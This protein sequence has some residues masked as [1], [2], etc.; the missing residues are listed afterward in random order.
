MLL[1]L[2]EQVGFLFFVGLMRHQGREQCE[3][4]GD[5]GNRKF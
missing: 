3:P 2:P 4:F 1:H 5:I